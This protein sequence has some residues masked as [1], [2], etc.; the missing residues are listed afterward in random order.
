MN[1]TSDTLIEGMVRSTALAIHDAEGRLDRIMEQMPIDDPRV[2]DE[3]APTAEERAECREAAARLDA[4]NE[5]RCAAR[6][7]LSAATRAHCDAL[8]L[9]GR[10]DC[11]DEDRAAV[12]SGWVLHRGAESV[13]VTPHATTHALSATGRVT[14]RPVSRARSPQRRRAQVR[15]S[16]RGGDSGDDSGGSDDGPGGED[17]QP[18]EHAGRVALVLL[19]SGYR[20]EGHVAIDS[21]GWVHLTAGRMKIGQ[22]DYV[23]YRSVLDQSWPRQ[24]VEWVRWI[25]DAR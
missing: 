22:G 2:E 3:D 13:A 15:S 25:E 20:Y 4:W 21:H 6:E 24:K 18:G 9:A 1:P 23:S 12:I 16:S 11:D 14:A 8:R 5:Q 17:G 10:A 19:R 7:G